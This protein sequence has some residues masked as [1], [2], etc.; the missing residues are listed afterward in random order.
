M[1]APAVGNFFRVNGRRDEKN[2][3]ILSSRL[4]APV[5]IKEQNAD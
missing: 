2:K 1:R 4:L 5:Q 3:G